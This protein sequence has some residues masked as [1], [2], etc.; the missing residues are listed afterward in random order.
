MTRY[1][2]AFTFSAA[3]LRGMCHYLKC[4]DEHGGT[5]IT[6]RSWAQGTVAVSQHQVAKEKIK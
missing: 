2:C 3:I 1:I 6:S 5:M 4:T